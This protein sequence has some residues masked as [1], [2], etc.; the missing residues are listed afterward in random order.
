MI[1]KK[2]KN[3]NID[4]VDSILK[5]KNSMNKKR[6][7]VEQPD[8]HK[9]II[10]PYWLL[11]FVEGEGYFCLKK[12]IKGQ[13]TGLELGLGQTESEYLVLKAVKDFLLI[14]PG[15]YELK[16]I[17]SNP[18]RHT[19]QNKAKN[20]K[21][22]PMTYITINDFN[23]IKNI[24]VPFFD[25]LTWLSKK[26]Q[27]YKD[28]K[29]ILSFISEG[30]HFT[31]EGQA[32]IS[33]INQRMNTRRLSTNS[34]FIF[35]DKIEIRIQNLLEAASNN[36]IHDNGKIFIISQGKYLK[37]RGN[38]R[39]VIYN[40]EDILINSFNSIKNCA[41]FFQVSQRTIIRRLDSGNMFLF[42]NQKFFIKR[43]LNKL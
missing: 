33:F 35:S 25:N 20:I 4:L 15:S 26:E 3:I 2:E 11:G 29:I 21:S 13:F 41:Q 36:E 23:Y 18:V 14:L 30:K 37:G 42:N 19:L 5:L 1:K 10:T 32:L 17:D 6:N 28:W 8:N 38:V 7:S 24:L 12:S 40:F 9:I 34:P 31:D 27:D 43:T 16:R 22:K 39:L